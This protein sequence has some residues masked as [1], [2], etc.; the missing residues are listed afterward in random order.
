MPSLWA[1]VGVTRREAL[2]RARRVSLWAETYR[3][4]GA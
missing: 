4:A 3:G 1:L 2:K